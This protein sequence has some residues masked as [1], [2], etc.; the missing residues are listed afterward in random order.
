[1]SYCDGIVTFNRLDGRILQTGM[2]GS[3]QLTTDNVFDVDF[4]THHPHIPNDPFNLW[5]YTDQGDAWM[6]TGQH[7]IKI[8]INVNGNIVTHMNVDEKN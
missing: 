5:V 1:M 3:I 7:W 6:W 8:N 4:F 2:S